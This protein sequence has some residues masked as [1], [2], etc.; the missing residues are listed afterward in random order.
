L[1]EDGKYLLNNPLSSMFDFIV[2]R[3]KKEMLNDKKVLEAFQ[4]VE[5]KREEYAMKNNG[6]YYKL[7]IPQPLGRQFLAWLKRTVKRFLGLK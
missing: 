4:Q 2:A 7:S 5:N 6:Q 1:E 3:P